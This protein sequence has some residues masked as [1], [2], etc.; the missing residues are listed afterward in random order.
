MIGRRK[1][2]NARM[3]H[4]LFNTEHAAGAQLIT[5][6]A[7]TLPASSISCSPQVRH[8]PTLQS[9]KRH[10]Q[11]I[12]INTLQTHQVR[13]LSTPLMALSQE[14]V[15]SGGTAVSKSSQQ[16][17]RSDCFADGLGTGSCT[18]G[19]DVVFIGAGTL[20]NDSGIDSAQ[21]EGFVLHGCD[22][23]LLRNT[24]SYKQEHR[25]TVY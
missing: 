6:F 11:Q 18:E 3:R 14:N 10:M 8:N 5:S 16:T 4:E 25:S 17:K 20:L 22:E 2:L 23:G 9:R 19:S 7:F 15:E 21:V 12:K 13:L 1:R 24:R